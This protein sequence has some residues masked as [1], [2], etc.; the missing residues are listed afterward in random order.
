MF[1]VL[2]HHIYVQL[3]RTYD[4]H[5]TFVLRFVILSP[6]FVLLYRCAE[7]PKGR[8]S[9]EIGEQST[10][11]AF[12]D[13]RGLAGPCMEGRWSNRTGLSAYQQCTECAVG[14]FSSRIAATSAC[15]QSCPTGR[16]SGA[17][18]LSSAAHCNVCIGGMG[19][20]CSVCL[21]GK[22]ISEVN[23]CVDCLAGTFTQFP[24]ATACTDCEA[25]R[26]SWEGS[27]GCFES[28]KCDLQAA[29]LR[30]SLCRTFLTVFSLSSRIR[31]LTLT[32]PFLL[33]F[34][35]EKV[36]EMSR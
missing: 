17:T 21:P 22:Y 25:G 34:V 31:I 19:G 23:V 36:L 27:S 16:W 3:V 4:F 1:F 6:K 14:R 2:Y 20:N 33:P 12:D 5:L 30:T 7:F 18:G 8:W 10:V 35:D 11:A 15:E 29:L 32:L 28:V 24:G 13:R 26:H 9:R